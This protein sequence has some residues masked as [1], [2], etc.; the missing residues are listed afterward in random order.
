MSETRVAEVARIVSHAD[1]LLA[2]GDV[3]SAI[4]LLT[5]ANR[6]Q[7][8]PDLERAL[9][10]T[11]HEGVA[12]LPAPAR[13]IGGA[14]VI[15]AESGGDLFEVDA[16]HLTAATVRAGFAQSGC[17]LVR[18]LVPPERVAHLV[19]GKPPSL[20]SSAWIVRVR[21]SAASL[22]RGLKS[23]WRLRTMRSIARSL[24]G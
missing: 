7:Q 18:G 5:G 22:S 1:A 9:V 17:V 4:D 10:R 3:R 2:G 6:Q 16:A 15:V 19:D 20:S 23:S 21:C 8:T 14:P 24:R 11:R 12:S 13:S